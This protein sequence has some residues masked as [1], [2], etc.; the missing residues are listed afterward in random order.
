MI[1]QT[2][3]V[4]F[5]ASRLCVKMILTLRRKDAKELQNQLLILVMLQI[6][7]DDVEDAALRIA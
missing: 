6:H 5:A 4:F 2:C 3:G 7:L 1:G